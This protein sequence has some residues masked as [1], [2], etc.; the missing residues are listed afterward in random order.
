[1]RLT[2][3]RM[4]VA[5]IHETGLSACQDAR[6]H[7]M[8]SARVHTTRARGRSAAKRMRVQIAQLPSASGD[9]SKACG[10]EPS[11][12]FNLPEARSRAKHFFCPFRHFHPPA[13]QLLYLLRLGPLPRSASSTL[14]LQCGSRSWPSAAVL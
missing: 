5:A 13:R 12:L 7:H 6:C 2:H 9:K 4:P 14:G 8:C 3:V 11:D 1:M 10:F